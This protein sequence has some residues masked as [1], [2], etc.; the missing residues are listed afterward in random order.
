MSE[1]SVEV[2]ASVAERVVPEL[3]A[4][5]GDRR[6]RFL[7]IVDRALMDRPPSMRRQI[8][9]FLRLVRWLPL[10]RFGL[11]FER[12]AASRQDRVLRWLQACPVPRL[13]QGFW[14]L[15]S[16]T[17]MGYYG[18]EETWPEI[19]YAPTFDSRERLDA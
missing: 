11:P 6:A 16:L 4:I 8:G 13:R 17:F 19:G 18:Q 5:D 1:R 2:L 12:L 14:G 7:A 10:A 3:Q 9:L 15:K